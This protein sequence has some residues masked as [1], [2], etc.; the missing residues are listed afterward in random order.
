M[1]ILGLPLHP[2]VVHFAVV[3]LPLGAAAVIASVL[4][5]RVRSRYGVLALGTLTA[6]ALTAIVARLSGEALAEQVGLPERHATF[7]TALLITSLAAAAL[8]W[9]WWWLER[10]RDAA[11]PGTS[12]LAAMASGALAITA[13]VAVI[14]L[15]VVTGHSGA[16]AVWGAGRPAITGPGAAA[17]P[18]TTAEAAKTYTLEQVAQ[19]NQASDCWAAVDG[20]VYDLTSWIGQHPGGPQRIL[21]LC[22]TDATQAF[23]TQHDSKPRPNNQLATMQV[24]VLAE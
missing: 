4:W 18:T 1:S 23:T 17:E 16:E 8:G 24:G 2:L 11:P 19:H 21:N 12:P 20:K 6:G 9:L 7:G 5:Q 22:G 10:R 13:S 3:A 15:A 14:G